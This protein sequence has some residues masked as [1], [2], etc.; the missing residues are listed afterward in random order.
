MGCGEKLGGIQ[1]DRQNELP[2]PATV[3]YMCVLGGWNPIFTE[4]MS[5]GLEEKRWTLRFNTKTCKQFPQ[6][7][8]FS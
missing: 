4:V 3:A 6:L 5:E 2:S 8:Q 7:S 1:R